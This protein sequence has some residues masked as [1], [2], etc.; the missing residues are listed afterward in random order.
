MAIGFRFSGMIRGSAEAA[1]EESGSFRARPLAG[2]SA[3]LIP[4]EP[5]R[6]RNRGRGG[7]RLGS[8]CLSSRLGF[9]RPNF[10]ELGRGRIVVANASFRALNASLRRQSVM[11][12]VGHD[13]GEQK[14]GRSRYQWR[15]GGDRE[16]R[17]CSHLV[18]QHE[19]A[20]ER[21]HD[22]TNPAYSQRPTNAR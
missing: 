12:G 7:R 1:R 4:A 3:A 11:R 10:H 13:P 9:G 20:N 14:S 18:S 17:L 22:R 19:P 21:P 8:G 6:G 2:G 15:N 16:E 5:G